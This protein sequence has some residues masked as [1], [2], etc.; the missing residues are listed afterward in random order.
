ME[1]FALTSSTPLKSLLLQPAQS[2]S[3]AQATDWKVALTQMAPQ[4][5]LSARPASSMVHRGC[6]AT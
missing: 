4:P 2:S 6:A 1:A 3:D 5:L